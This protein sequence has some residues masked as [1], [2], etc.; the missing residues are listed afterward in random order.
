M[1]DHAYG[2]LPPNLQAQRAALAE[3]LSNGGAAP[4]RDADP[5]SPPM[6]GQRATRR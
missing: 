5:P 6:R 3:R 4:S 2:E 1:F